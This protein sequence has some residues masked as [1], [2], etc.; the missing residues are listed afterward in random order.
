MSSTSHK[1]VLQD[2]MRNLGGEVQQSVARPDGL[3][4][5]DADDLAAP[6]IVKGTD[7]HSAAV[8]KELIDARTEAL[9]L[10]RLLTQN[11]KG[12]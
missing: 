3:V 2:I 11:R 10:R 1:S 5:I 7:I 12:S 8:R 4:P 6:F 9:N